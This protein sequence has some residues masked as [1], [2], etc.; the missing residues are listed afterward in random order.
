MIIKKSVEL[1]LKHAQP[2][3]LFAEIV[4]SYEVESL[5]DV[6][7]ISGSEND[8][9]KCHKF[10]LASASNFLKSLL[11]EYFEDDEICIIIPDVTKSELSCLVNTLYGKQQSENDYFDLEIFR[12]LG[13]ALDLEQ[14]ETDPESLSDVYEKSKLETVMTFHLPIDVNNTDQIEQLQDVNIEDINST[15]VNDL[16]VDKDFT[17]LEIDNSQNSNLETIEIGKPV[18]VIK[19]AQNESPEMPQDKV[20]KQKVKCDVCFKKF[21]SVKKLQVHKLR[22]HESENINGF[23]CIHCNMILA[24]ANSLEIHIRSHTGHRPFAC[25]ECDKT[26]T[27]LHYLVQHK[28]FHRKTKDFECDICLKKYQNGNALSQHRTDFHSNVKFQCDIC[29]K[30]FSAKRYLREHERKKHSSIISYDCDI[31]G[32]TLSGKNELKIHSR[33]HTGEKPFHCEEC[34]K[35]FR[36]RSTYTIHMKSHSGTKNAVCDEC[37]KRF[38][39]WGD[40]RKHKRTHTGE[41]PF[42][43][44][45]C[46]RAF[47]RKDYL[48]KHER[49]HKSEKTETS[50]ENK[51]PM[52]P[53]TADRVAVTSI[54]RPA[55][56]L[57]ESMMIDVSELRSL[58]TEDGSQIQVVTILDAGRNLVEFHEENSLNI[59][60]TMKNNE[61]VMYVI[62]N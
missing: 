42:N 59:D 39:Q 60:E 37:G 36:A 44:N 31:C 25:S 21:G 24:T 45:A 62:T 58:V 30:L 16:D 29:F 15:I 13:V 18:N 35:D 52:S 11:G 56:V 49:T 32:K 22:T 26:F 53:R 34:N 1:N 57:E 28:D 12:M 40:L 4:K 5:V 33:I 19:Y 48:T 50:Q 61:N 7:L 46:G 14:V 43:C 41:R 20:L 10:M 6:K 17:I 2:E 3:V 9:I 55:E 27:S 23:K 51:S 47:A 8:P 38:I 54:S